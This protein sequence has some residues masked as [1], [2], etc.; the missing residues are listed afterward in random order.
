M[1]GGNLLGAHAIRHFEKLV[2]LDEIVAKRARN[3]CAAGKIVVDK[4]L[5]DLLF[6]TIF[7]IDDVIR[8]VENR[9]DEASVVDIIE[10]TAAAC[11]AAFGH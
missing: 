3:G 8:N 11:R 7:E 5:D 10:R 4:R 9:G 1:A 2:E 6:E